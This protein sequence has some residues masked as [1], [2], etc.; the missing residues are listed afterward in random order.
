[1]IG[2]R[3]LKTYQTVFLWDLETL[4]DKVSDFLVRDCIDNRMSF[5][6]K[7]QE[8]CLCFCKINAMRIKVWILRR[9][10]LW[11]F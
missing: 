1:M 5:K 6:F 9:E 7:K 10:K 11:T 4:N 3:K 8:C 2:D